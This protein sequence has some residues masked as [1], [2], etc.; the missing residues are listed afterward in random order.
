[1]EI[2]KD[3]IKKIDNIMI[4]RYNKRFEKYGLEAKTLGWSCKED[5]FTRFEVATRYIDFWGKSILD[6]GCGFADFYE[7]LINNDIK[8]KKYKGIDINNKL[9][10]VARKRFPENKYEV[11]NILLNN[12]CIS[13]SD[14]ITL[15]GLLNLKWEIDNLTYTKEMITEA[16]KITKEI[17]VV[18]FLSIH[19]IK[20]YPKEDFIYYHNPKDVLDLCFELCDNVVL[21]HDYPPIPQKEFMVI[22]KKEI[23]GGI[24]K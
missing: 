5:Q 17:L 4:K 16:W 3:K 22:L 15:F 11:R 7:F 13:Q 18:D 14:I 10:E 21:V 20:E 19:L 12:Y 23:K 1:M 8:I 24:S 2:N 9:I 6:I